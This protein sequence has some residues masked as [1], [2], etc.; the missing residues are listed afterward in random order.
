MPAGGVRDAGG[1]SRTRSA[2]GSHQQG[3]SAAPSWPFATRR[4]VAA[5]VGHQQRPP[6][7]LDRRPHRRCGPR[8][9]AGFRIAPVRAPLALCG[10]AP[11]TSSS[12][13]DGLIEVP[14]GGLPPPSRQ[15]RPALRPGPRPPSLW[16]CTR[17]SPRRS[18]QGL[19][20]LITRPEGLTGAPRK[21]AIQPGSVH[22]RGQVVLVREQPPEERNGRLDPFDFVFA[23]G[24]GEARYR[25]RTIAAPRNQL[26]NHGIVVDGHV[27]RC[28]ET[29]IVAHARAGRRRG[30]G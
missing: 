3:R 26:R 18:R 19:P 13:A 25:L 24:T 15:S 23:Q 4:L 16:P 8:R 2:R 20:R 11:S 30:G 14:R 22:A 7:R 1:G 27:A 28:G 9:R 5:A 17:G 21:H 6:P 12:K 29:A 10:P